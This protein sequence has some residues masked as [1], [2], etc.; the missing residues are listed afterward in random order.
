MIA[1]KMGQKFPKQFLI[2]SKH[3]KDGDLL[4][5]INRASK[6]ERKRKLSN[7]A[8]PCLNLPVISF[9]TQKK[10]KNDQKQQ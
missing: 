8:F 9:Q 4:A 6:T 7:T 3:F 10:T 2:C 1:L 5:P